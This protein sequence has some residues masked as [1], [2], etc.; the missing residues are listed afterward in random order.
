ME[1]GSSS[2]VRDDTMPGVGVIRWKL[3]EFLRE[4]D[5]TPYSL[6]KEAKGVS[7]KVIYRLANDET[8]GVRFST[9]AAVMDGLMAIT[10]KKVTFD[11][12][13][14]FIDETD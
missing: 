10:G 2:G 4:H 12:L 3:K 13:L 5:V 14:E 8:E 11:D 1:A 9:L 7:Q 6:A